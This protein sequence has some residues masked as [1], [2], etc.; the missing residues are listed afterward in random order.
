MIRRATIADVPK[1]VKVEDLSFPVPWPDFFF[2]AHLNN[3]GF[4][5]Y[6]REGNILGY[7]IIGN[8]K[9]RAHLQNIAVHPQFRRQGI[10]AELIEWCI[11]LVKLY[12]YREM[13][14]EVREKN[15]ASQ[16]FYSNSGFKVSGT[17]EGY[18]VDENAVIMTRQI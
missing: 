4:V 17:V 8:S 5:V 13:V 2:K 9:G 1:I 11:D 15:T 12:G 14:L 6:E 18:Y 3:P 10:G 7:A 16:N